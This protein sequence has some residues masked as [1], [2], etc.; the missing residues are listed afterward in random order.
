[1]NK[2]FLSFMN[3]CLLTMVEETSD[4]GSSTGFIILMLDWEWIDSF[5]SYLS[6]SFFW[7]VLF[8]VPFRISCIIPL[9]CLKALSPLSSLSSMSS[10]SSLISISSSEL[11]DKN[12]NWPSLPP[13]LPNFKKEDGLSIYPPK[14]LK[15][16]AAS[17]SSS[18]G[19]SNL[20]G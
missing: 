15:I 18:S 16:I 9:T 6:T 19:A 12:Y 1:M 2:S 10:F 3:Y 14:C 11:S 7:A 5:F 8:A 4:K 20:D 13:T 17:S